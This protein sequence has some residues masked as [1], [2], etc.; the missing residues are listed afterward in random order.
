[1]PQHQSLNAEQRLAVEHLSGP[2]IVYAG[3][4]TGKTKML[5]HRIQHIL[6]QSNETTSNIL[7]L[8]FSNAGVASMKEKLKNLIGE[9]ADEVAIHTFHSFASQMIQ[10]SGRFKGSNPVIGHANAYMLIEMLLDEESKISLSTPRKPASAAMLQ[11]M[12]NFF[13][14]M[15]KESIDEELLNIYMTM[16]FLA[17]IKIRNTGSKTEI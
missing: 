16:R 13:G 6:E 9:K 15:K 3:P 11:S 5:V 7:C 2:V 17:L 1:M 4:G 10:L 8:T 12:I 14:Q